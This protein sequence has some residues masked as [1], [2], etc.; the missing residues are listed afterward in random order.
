MFAQ[1]N[2]NWQ[3][4]FPDP[5]MELG[6]QHLYSRILPEV[7]LALDPDRFYWAGSPA[8]GP[9]PDSDHEGD[10]HW[11][12]LATMHKDMDRRIRHE[13]YDECRSRFVSEW[14]VIGPCHVATMREYLRPDELDP[15][16]PA[17]R[18]HTNSFEKDTLAAAI[19]HHYQ[20]PEGMPLDR[21]VRCGQLV[22]AVL[23]GRSIES[24]RFRKRDPE[25]DCAGA[26][27]WMFNDCWGE[28]G[29]TPLDHALR[30]KASFHWIR[31]ACLP[32]RAL[33]R[34]RGDELVVRAVNDTRAAVRL[35]VH[36]GWLRIDGSATAVTAD[37]V[38]V[39]AN[40]MA[41]I[42]RAAIPGPERM[43]PEDWIF[44]TWAE[45]DGVEPVPCTWTLLPHRRLRT[46]DPGIAV[47]VD[48][49]RITLTARAYAHGVG[50]P[51]DGD[52][53]FS[54]NWFDLL[55]G[56][57]RTITCHGPL[58]ADLRFAPI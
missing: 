23:F 43:A 11:W 47:R 16:H 7:C 42:A 30:R 53:R 1:W 3:Y 58:P 9:L 14:G 46:V 39:G 8:G 50:H 44:A 28:T 12:G 56:V 24:M 17:F 19:R 22:Q 52:R 38:L 15:A 34:R 48:G 21:W 51:D 4:T 32:V 55:P 31:N 18:V 35:R 36:H 13:V 5:R 26:L 10:S 33:V 41:E 2:P 57:P 45:G 49:G 29:W 54:D 6:G 40:G 27:I 20:D 37:E 25:D